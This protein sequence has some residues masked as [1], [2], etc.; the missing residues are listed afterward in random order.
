MSINVLGAAC[1]FLRGLDVLG[2]N[3]YF[4]TKFSRTELLPALW[5]PTTAIC[6]RSSGFLVPSC[7]K[8]SYKET[9]RE[10]GEKEDQSAKMTTMT[11]SRSTFVEQTCS[12]FTILMRFCMPSLVDMTGVGSVLTRWKAVARRFWGTEGRGTQLEMP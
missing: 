3:T 5:P 2:L 7:E 10:R 1:I 11:A 4:P 6:G 12:L 8:A 9:E